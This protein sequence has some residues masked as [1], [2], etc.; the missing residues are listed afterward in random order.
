MIEA[1]GLTKR[2]DARTALDDLTLTVDAGEVVC[3]LGPNG[4]GKTTAI[5]LFLGFVQPTAGQ[6][7]V[8]GVD[9][10][11]HPIETK[12]SLA[13]IPEQVA[14]YRMLS[15]EENLK[16][17]ASLS[18][19]ADADLDVRALFDDVGLQ[20][21]AIG[22]RVETYSKGMRQKV[23][24]AIAVATGAD[25]FLLDE[26]TS[27]LDQTAAHEFSRLLLRLRDR[28]ATVLMATHD[29]Y[30]AKA[31]GD[32]VA[33]LS[34]GRLTTVVRTADIEYP[35]LES[36]YLQM[37]SGAARPSEYGSDPSNVS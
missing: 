13:Y 22:R 6:A 7:L 21:E 26:P 15:G 23:A 24:I 4:A 32:R 10:A 18:G 5:N 16:F 1:R 30:R 31:I 20:R 11:A 12:K 9:V 3:L 19:M 28:G 33:I 8:K 34:A 27:G 37:A 17:F 2:Y 25:V 29:L 14:L 36:L 35:E